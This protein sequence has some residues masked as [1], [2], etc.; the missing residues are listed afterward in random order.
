MDWL[1]AEIGVLNWDHS[2]LQAY[3]KRHPEFRPR[4]LLCIMAWSYATGVFESG[5]VVAA[6]DTEPA[7]KRACGDCRPT[8]EALERFR[9]WNRGLIRWSLHQLYR[10]AFR[11]KF[12]LGTT[13]FPPG[14][15]RQL[16]EAARTR[17]DIARQMDRGEGGGPAAED[18]SPPSG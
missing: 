10:R 18:V 12:N 4:A 8:E 14:L 7:L 11:V 2:E 16:A 9:K 1:E 6:C 13:W 5:E 15:N 17:M 3:L